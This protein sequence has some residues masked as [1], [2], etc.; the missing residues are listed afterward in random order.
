ML[1]VFLSSSLDTPFV[2][3]TNT[4]KHLYEENKCKSLTEDQLKKP[5][6]FK[7]HF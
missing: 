4:S 3:A 2:P 1:Y 5:Y 7:T 6:A